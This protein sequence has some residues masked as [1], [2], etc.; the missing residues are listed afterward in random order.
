LNVVDIGNLR[1]ERIRS[2]VE[3]WLGEDVPIFIH[4]IA[5]GYG[6]K[7]LRVLVDYDGTLYD[8]KRVADI[9]HS[10]IQKP[11]DRP[12]LRLI[13]VDSDTLGEVEHER[14]RRLGVKI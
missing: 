10:G 12:R 11:G 7:E 4:L 2:A 13:L 1:K 9:V 3:K 5:D 6:D 8:K 14:I